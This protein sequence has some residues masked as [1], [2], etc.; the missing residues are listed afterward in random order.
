MISPTAR[1]DI[2]RAIDRGVK[3]TPEDIIR[4]NALGLR[5]DY[6][7]QGADMRIMPRVAW[8]GEVAFR[9]PTIGHEI[10][11]RRAGDIFAL[12]RPED[13][14]LLRAFCLA[15]PPEALPPLDDRKALLAAVDAF[16]R[17]RLSFYTVEQVAA[18]LVYA[19]QGVD[20][21]AGEIPE[22]KPEEPLRP[23]ATPKPKQPGETCYEVGLLRNGVLLKLGSPETL[24]KMTVSELETLV[25]ESMKADTR[26]GAQYAKDLVSRAFADYKRTL[27]AILR[28][29]GGEG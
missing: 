14:V 17:T 4:L 13:I 3:L 22:P 7:K 10:W 24:R 26:I 5:H 15:T 29:R 21:A 16:C 8:L 6:A 23:G 28:E 11:M 27:S 12:E 20:P 18:A 19:E 9:E 1:A 2:R 25:V